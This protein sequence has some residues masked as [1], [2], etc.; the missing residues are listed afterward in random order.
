MTK[1][2]I[3]A[4]LS[5]LIAT[6]AIAAPAADVV[7]YGHKPVPLDGYGHHATFKHYRHYNHGHVWV[8]PDDGRSC[9][10]LERL[11]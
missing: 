6:S 2:Q 7:G 3:I 10:G 8:K 9:V 11:R 4:A 1:T 5:G